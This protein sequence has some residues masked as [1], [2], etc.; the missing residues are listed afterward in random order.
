MKLAVLATVAVLGAALL[1]AGCGGGSSSTGPAG[2]ASGNGGA[3]TA[4]APNAPPGSRVVTCSEG[5]AETEQLRAAAVDCATARATMRRWQRSHACTL[6]RSASRSSCSLG[7]FRCQAVRV[8]R[9]ASVSCAHADGD[10]SF[11]AKAW[12]LRRTGDG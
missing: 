1:A 2:G 11:I 5:G 9:G 12:L 3:K 4:T 7:S 6:G 10:V 8:G